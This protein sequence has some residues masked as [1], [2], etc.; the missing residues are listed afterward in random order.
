MSSFADIFAALTNATADTTSAAIEWPGGYC[1]WTN[2]GTF[3][4][5]RA[6][7]K[8]ASPK[9]GGEYIEVDFEDAAAAV[10][11]VAP[12]WL[13]AGS[14]LVALSGADAE[15]ALSSTVQRV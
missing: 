4:A 12:I 15:T 10:R 7:L 9:W 8:F 14:I 3:G 6:S 11:T 1:L 2:S 5:A 13:E